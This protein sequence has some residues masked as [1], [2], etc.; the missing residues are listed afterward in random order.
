MIGAAALVVSIIFGVQQC[1]NSGSSTGAGSST[2]VPP[3]SDIPSVTATVTTASATA[4]PDEESPLPFSA[5]TFRDPQPWSGSKDLDRNPWDLGIW[6][7]DIN[8]LSVGQDYIGGV[9]MALLADGVSATY[10]IC[11]SQTYSRTQ[12]KWS[13]MKPGSELCIRVKDPKNADKTRVGQLTI[14]S[15][16]I[17]SKGVTDVSFTGQV[18]EPT[19]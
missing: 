15:F 5:G 2:S 13:E 1:S 17:S 9:Q 18:W 12:V 10:R 8:Y 6:P 19:R 11:R 7:N 14:G 4:Q 3:T 16:T